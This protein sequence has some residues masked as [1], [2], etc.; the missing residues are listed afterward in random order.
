MPTSWRCGDTLRPAIAT[1]VKPELYSA[2]RKAE[3]LLNNA[4][5]AEDYA[6]ARLS[7]GELG[8]DPDVVPHDPPVG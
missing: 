1:P 3:F 8:L 4:V 6:R 7:V 2:M 5:D